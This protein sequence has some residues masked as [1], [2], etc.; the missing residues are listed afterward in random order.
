MVFAHGQC[1]GATL[2]KFFFER[3]NQRLW[4]A[5]LHNFG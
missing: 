4:R 2:A 3:V 5:A 1:C